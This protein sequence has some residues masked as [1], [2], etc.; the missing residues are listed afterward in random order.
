LI[1][2]QKYGIN[3]DHQTKTQLT[4][5]SFPLQKST[6]KKVDRSAAQKKSQEPKPARFSEISSLKPTPKHLPT[7]IQVAFQS[8][9]GPG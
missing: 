1:D 8:L 7:L 5:D 6:K 2:C 4:A 3:H 9:F